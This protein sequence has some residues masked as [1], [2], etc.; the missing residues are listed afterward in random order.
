MNN[1]KDIKNTA[2]NTMDDNPVAKQK[3]WFFLLDPGP[4]MVQPLWAK[5]VERLAQRKDAPTSL[6][7]GP[8]PD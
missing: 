5:R 4:Q 2:N 7:L 1:N 8:P 3:D 6:V